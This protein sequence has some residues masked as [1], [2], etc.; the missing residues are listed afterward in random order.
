M[1]RIR[2]LVGGL[3][4]VHSWL[5]PELYNELVGGANESAHITGCAVDFHASNMNCDKVRERL[6]KHLIPLGIRMEKNPGS[7]WVHIDIRP[8]GPSG[9]FFSP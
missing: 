6:E 2:E 1:E 7:S 8:P 5:R 9:R 4:H 3:I